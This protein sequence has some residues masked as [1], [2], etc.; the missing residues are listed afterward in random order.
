MK[1]TCAPSD[2]SFEGVETTLDVVL[3]GKPKA[4]GQ[5]SAGYALKNDLLRQRV[6]PAPRAWDLLAIAL[7]VISADLAGHR[8][9]STDGW[10]RQFD[11][12]IAVIEPDF[13]ATQADLLRQLLCYLSGDQ[14]TLRF[15]GG[16]TVPE[17]SKPPI[18]PTE[19]CV[20]LLSGGLD[21]FIGTIDLAVQ[22]K[23]P[24]VVSQ[25]V[26]GDAVKQAAFAKMIGGG[27]RHV[28]VHHTAEIPEPEEPPSQRARSIVFLAYGVFMATTLLQHQAGN[29]VTLFVCENGLISLNPPLTGERLGSLSTRTTHPVVFSILQQVLDAASLRVKIENPYSLKTKGEMMLECSDQVLLASHAHETTSCGRFKKFGYKHC[30]R[31]VPCLVRRAAFAATSIPDTTFYVYDDLARD[32]DDHAGFED[33][34]AALMA[35]VDQQMHGTRRWLGATISSPRIANKQALTQTAE[36][37]LAEIESLLKG[38]GVR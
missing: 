16:G 27:L 23:K 28:Q 4:L 26:R 20:V 3:F 2:Y 32:D 6:A 1:I 14:W 13:W 15:V 17:P 30:G 5:G 33:V 7:S 24:L 36:R 11:L 25:T 34:R 21:S 18:H 35:A 12:T 10:T 9:E 29:D 8:D 38:M 19:D 37:G 22:G 31:C